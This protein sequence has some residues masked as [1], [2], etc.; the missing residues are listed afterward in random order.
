MNL[1][2][3]KDNLTTPL[4]KT[5]EQHKAP[6]LSQFNSRDDLTR[7]WDRA[8]GMIMALHHI[9]NVYGAATNA[10]PTQADFTQEI[11]PPQ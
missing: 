8:E 1:L 11:L 2:E 5:I 9:E 4:K 3:F 7:Q 6:T 10:E